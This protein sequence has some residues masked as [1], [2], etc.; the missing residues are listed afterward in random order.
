MLDSLTVLQINLKAMREAIDRLYPQGRTTKEEVREK[1]LGALMIDDDY[2][3]AIRQ[4]FSDCDLWEDWMA[5]PLLVEV[6]EMNAFQ[7][8]ISELIPAIS[9]AALTNR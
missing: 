6:K 4:H 8:Q 9:L 7:D 3:A 5:E 2:R 1:P